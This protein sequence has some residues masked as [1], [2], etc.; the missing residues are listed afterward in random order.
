MAI[1]T[2]EAGLRVY[3]RGRN[4]DGTRS[5]TMDEITPICSGIDLEGAVTAASRKLSLSVVRKNADYYLSKI[6]DIKR[7]DAIA[8]DD[9]GEDY[10][11]YGLVW[12]TKDDDSQ[13]LKEIVCYD[14]MKFL[15]TSEAITNVWNN[16]TPNE[17]TETICKELGVTCGDLPECEDKVSVNAREKT[18]YEA[19]MIA[20][21]E[22]HKLNGKVYYPRMVGH[23]LTVIEKGAE[24]GDGHTLKHYS[25]DLPGS[26]ITTTLEEN[27]ESAVTSL[28]SRNGAGTASHIKTDDELSKLLGYIVGMRDDAQTTDQMDVKQINDGEKVAT[29]EAIGDWAMQTGWSVGIESSVIVE[30]RL[31]IESD[32]HHYENGIHTMTLELSYENTMDEH[33]NTPIEE[34]DTGDITGNTVEEYMWNYMRGKMGFSAAAAAGAMGNAWAESNCTPDITEVNGYGGYG[35]FQWTFSRKTDLQNWC[36]NNGY[37][38]TTKEGQMAFFEF[39][40]GLQYYSQ[41]LGNSYAQL[42]DVW[43]ATDRFLTYFEGCTVRTEIVHW[44]TRIS[45]A[46]EYY[47]KWKDYVTI[48]T[49][50][51]GGNRVEGDGNATGNFLWP[52]PGASCEVVCRAGDTNNAG[53]FKIG[54]GHNVVACDGGTV[55]WVQ[56]WDGRNAYAYYIM[57][58]STYGNCVLINHGN[59]YTTRYAHLSRIDVVVGQKVSR[60]QQIGVSGNTGRS[61][62]AHLHLEIVRNGVGICPN[63]INWSYS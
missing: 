51:T 44:N 56:P 15:M 33:E 28:W 13:V 4:D 26:I 2:K 19:M 61:F 63:Y 14:N 9:G 24:L 59:G 7:G 3:L 62:G 57:D 29:V 8:L 55:T 17:V 38:Y 58:N 31:Y 54:E 20:W 16:V 5:N 39:E 25:R 45:K 22:A 49:G 10:V 60:G 41:F 52:L 11:F 36:V 50:S 42:D 47:A 12:E 23:R 27:S 43:T 37:N 53:D 18:G 46:K 35:L 48:P 40:W 21:T 34:A 32:Q 1:G 30:D 6:A